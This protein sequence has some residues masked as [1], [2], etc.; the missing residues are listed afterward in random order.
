MT[1]NDFEMIVMTKKIQNFYLQKI[2][3]KYFISKF[4]QS[5]HTQQFEMKK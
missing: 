1:F 4:L 2:K 3:Y 5:C